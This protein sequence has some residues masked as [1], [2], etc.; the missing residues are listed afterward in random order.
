MRVT[1]VFNSDL[2]LQEQQLRQLAACKQ[3]LD[4][5][6]GIPLLKA[7]S[8]TYGDFSKVKVRHRKEKKG[9][10]TEAFNAAFTIPNIRQRAIFA[11][12]G[13][14]TTGDDEE[15]YFIF[16]KDGY[17]F[18][19]SKEVQDSGEEYREVFE[20]LL[21]KFEQ[22]Q[23]KAIG[24]TTDLLRYNYTDENLAEGLSCQ[25]EIIVYNVP[26]FYAVSPSA[27]DYDNLLT[28]LQ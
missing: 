5:S 17:Q 28:L 14:V 7:L 1:D 13:N 3:F 9:T 24:I 21:N 4:E 27:V 20:S 6:K 11:Q 18:V 15:A 12:G 19:Y 26:F 8:W 25:A 10:F 16:P 23:Q 2:P 22:E